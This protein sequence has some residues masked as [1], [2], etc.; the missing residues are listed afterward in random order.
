MNTYAIDFETY[1]DKENSITT[2]GQWHYLRN[3]ASDIYLVAIHGPDI[4]YV[5]SPKK[6]PWAKIDGHKWVAH[7]YSFDGAVIERLREQGCVQESKPVAWDCTAN[8]SVAVGAPRNLLGASRELLGRHIDKD[9]REKMH[10]KKWSDVENTEFGKEVLEYAR[11]DAK[12]CLGIYEKFSDQMLSTEA[13]LSRHTIEMGWRGIQ[14]DQDAV[15]NGIKA[16]QKVTWESEN[17]L[18]W[19]DETD[20]VVL[21]TKAFRR[22]CAKAGIPWPTSLAE[23]SEECA[24]WESQYGEKVPFVGI[25]RDWRKAN[26]LLAK[27]KVM[28]SRIKPDGTMGY[29]LKYMGAHTGRWSGDSKFNVQNLPRNE[30]FGVD[31]RGCIIPRPGKKFVICDLAQIEPRV[32]AWLSGNE[33]L[34]Q[35]IKNGYG[36]YEAAAKNM[37]LWDGP[38]GTLKKTDAPLYQLVKAMVLG[39]GYGAGAKKFALIAKMQY[40]IDMT[41]TKS[42]MIVNDFRTRNQPILDLWRKLEGDFQ[43]AKADKQF[44][45]GLP[46]GR[47]LTY[48][49]IMSQWPDKQKYDKSGKARKAAWTASVERG[50]PQIPFYGGKLCENLVQAVARDVMGAAV[51]RLEK[52]G[53]PVVMHIH[54]EAVCEVDNSVPAGEIERLMSVCPEWLDGCPIGAE[55]TDAV[56]YKK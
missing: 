38:K 7:N 47:V 16:L 1:Y 34:L 27:L 2:L 19:I 5:G 12:A 39:L 35:A 6:A 48:R 26:S 3:P 53:C 11:Q 52:A 54:D 56:R 49:N 44:E 14:V 15:N 30:M 10:S 24:L 43:R 42:N 41:E 21:S 32:L 13:D 29:G 22:E 50:G 20:G 9:P 46:S 51:L 33:G 4:D 8:L 23:N 45:V 31:L 55:A 37:G 40:G 17:A 28:Q 36:I 25:M 18:P